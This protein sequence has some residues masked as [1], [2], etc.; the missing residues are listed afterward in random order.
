MAVIEDMEVEVV[1]VS[2]G[3]PLVE[4]RHA[5][6]DAEAKDRETQAYIEAIT[7]SEFKIVVGLKKGFNY[8]GADGITIHLTIDGD[9]LS[10]TKYR[11]RPYGASATSR[12]TEDVKVEWTDILV[13][14][15]D[16]WSKVAF[17]FGAADIGSSYNPF[18]FYNS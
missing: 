15:G 5:D 8:H 16:N 18:V 3:E 7:G 13:G 2:S 4:Y 9:V 1:S 12:L 11:S 10:R 17:S 14:S 6:L